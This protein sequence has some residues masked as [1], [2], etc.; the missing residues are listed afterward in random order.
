MSLS[1]CSVG[2]VMNIIFFLQLRVMENIDLRIDF[3]DAKILEYNSYKYKLERMIVG[4]LIVSQR[5]H[6]K[7]E[8]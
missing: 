2:G 4:F 7:R 3:D 1:M 8:G 5:Q 6:H